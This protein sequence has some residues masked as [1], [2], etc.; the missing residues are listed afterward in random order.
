[1]ACSPETIWQLRSMWITSTPWSMTSW[2]SMSNST[3]SVWNRN[4]VQ[5][6]FDTICSG[7]WLAIFGTTSWPCLSVSVSENDYWMS[8]TENV[9]P[10]HGTCPSVKMLFSALHYSTWSQEGFWTLAS[11]H[12]LHLT[13]SY[14]C[15]SISDALQGLWGFPE[16]S[17]VVRE[18]RS[19]SGTEHSLERREHRGQVES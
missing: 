7:L 9:N 1:M 14:L 10:H 13:T 2:P 11:A 18:F 5:T 15:M 17:E 19:K 12:A 6:L 3:S 4:S 8:S 16:V